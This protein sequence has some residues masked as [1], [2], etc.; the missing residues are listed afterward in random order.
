MQIF[1]CRHLYRSQGSTVRSGS[2]EEHTESCMS[3]CSIDP[4][5]RTKR[6]GTKIVHRRAI[7]RARVLNSARRDIQ[8]YFTIGQRDDELIGRFVSQR[9]RM[10]MHI[11]LLPVFVAATT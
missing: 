2:K 9:D 8:R 3:A 1:C 11:R 6:E 7:V 10:D 4:F 5:P